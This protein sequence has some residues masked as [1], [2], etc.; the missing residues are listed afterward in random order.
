ME[1]EKIVVNILVQ[2]PLNEVWRGWTIPEE[3]KLWNIPFPNWHCPVVIN[4]LRDGGK[5]CFR[6]ETKD[7]KENFDHSGRY[8]KII[9]YERIEYTLDDGRKSIT[10]F[11]QIDSNTIIRESFEPEKLVPDAVQQEFCESVLQHFKKYLE[12]QRDQ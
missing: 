9:P 6:M 11:L 1:A 10:E 3:I 5:F 2:K 12:K 4:D 7:G 8:D